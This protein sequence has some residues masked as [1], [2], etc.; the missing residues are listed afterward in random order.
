LI[1]NIDG[2]LLLNNLDYDKK[3][4]ISIGKKSL[5]LPFVKSYG[6]AKNKELL[7]TIGSSNFFEISI[8]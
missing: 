1:T 2:T 6:L 7:A 3:I 4:K 8:L 5:E